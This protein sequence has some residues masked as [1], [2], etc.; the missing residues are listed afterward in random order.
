MAVILN[1]TYV[2]GRKPTKADV[3]RF[4]KAF[5]HRAQRRYRDWCEK[6]GIEPDFMQDAV[7]K[8]DAQSLENDFLA[9]RKNTSIHTN[10]TIC[11]LDP[12][13]SFTYDQ[14]RPI[15]EAQGKSCAG[16]G[17]FGTMA[18]M[19]GDHIIPHSR[20]G[21]TEVWNAQV[22]CR[23]CNA[24]K[25]DKDPLTWAHENGVTLSPLF[26][27]KYHEGKVDSRKGPT[28]WKYKNTS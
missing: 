24:R 15:W 26:I 25:N 14:I 18:K 23:S 17:E 10:R 13:R 9:A 22:L 11:T 12:N 1:S 4:I 16:C 3:E 2:E 19:Q 7:R 6:R 27:K 20:G 5:P 21:V 28:Y 8:A